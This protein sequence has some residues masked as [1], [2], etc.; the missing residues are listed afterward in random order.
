MAIFK[1]ASI[2]AAL[3]LATVANAAGADRALTLKVG[4]APPKL[5][6]SHW[7]KG[8]P[9]KSFQPGKTY[10]VEFWATW[11]GPCKMSIPH[12]TEMQKTYKDVKFIGV[13]IW[14]D[15]QANVEPFVKQMGDKMDYTVAMD[16]LPAA[17]DPK[18]HGM[19]GQMAQTWMAAAGENGIPTAF[20][21]KDQHVVWIGHPM[22]M[23]D[24]LKKVIA[25]TWDVDA[26]AKEYAAKK[27]AEQAMMEMQDKLATALKNKDWAGLNAVIKDAYNGAAHDD[28][29]TINQLVWPSVDPKGGVKDPDLAL[30]QDMMEH[31]VS[32]ENRKNYASLDTLARVYFLKGDKDKAIATEKEA[33]ALAPA[34]G[35]A[36]LEASLKE[37][38]G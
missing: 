13:S 12:L 14:E 8:T 23:E 35:K 29:A 5:M 32:L 18:Q 27:A 20:I 25:G 37:F 15:S 16:Q 1:H 28:A 10:V 11:C 34:D 6:I 21:V 30:F 3:I 17:A 24:P 7:V 26:F 36:D 22:L 9:I 33:I 4:D 19:D 2:A 38:G 31:A